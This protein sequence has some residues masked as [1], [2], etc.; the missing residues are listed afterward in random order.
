MPRS[1]S[2][3]FNRI[4][5]VVTSAAIFTFALSLF[6]FT[7][8]LWS[9]DE[10]PAEAKKVEPTSVEAVADQLEYNRG[11]KKVIGKGNVVV[12]YGNVKLTAD[13]AEVETE[14]KRAYA[15]GHVIIIK[16]DHVAARGEEVYYDFGNDK[17][18]FPNG[19]AVEEPWFA[20]GKKV[21]QVGKDKIE[22]ENGGVTTCDLERPHYEVRAKK[23][24]IYTGDKM[25]AKDVTIEILGKKVFWWPY[26]VIPLNDNGESPFEIQPGYSSRAGAYILTSKGISINKSMWGRV[27]LDWRSKRGVG[28]GVDLGYHFEK[29]NTRGSLQTY[30]TQDHVAPHAGAENPYSV[31]EERIRGR[32]TWKQRTNFDPD[33]YAMLRF[34]K[35]SD[36]HVL[37]DFFHKEFRADVDPTSFAVF[38]KNT[39]RFGFYAFNQKKM[40]RYENVIEKLPEVRFDWKTAPILSDKVYYENEWSLSNLNQKYKRA[41][42]DDNTFRFDTFHQLSSPQKWHEIKLTPA[43]NLRETMYSRSQYDN[44]PLARTAFGGFVD[45]RTQFYK[46][47]DA[48]ADF[49][50]IEINQLRHVLEPV[51][52]YDTVLQSNVSRYKLHQF[53]SIDAI[54]DAN[55]VSFGVENR[56]QTKRVVE[57]KMKRVDLV[58]LNTYLSYDFHPDEE[59]SRSGFSILNGELQIRPYEWLQYQIRYEYDMTRDNFREF[60]QDFVAHTGRFRFVFGHRS[61]AKS[62]YLNLDGNDQFVFDANVWI[63]TRWSVGGY[64]RWNQS[65]VNIEEWQ[66]SATRDLHDFLLDF[67]YNVR[68]SLI[69]DSNKE[70]F[71]LLRLKAFPQYPLRTGN[72]ASFGQP[73]IGTTVAGSNQASAGAA[74]E[75]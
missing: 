57:G 35:A 44:D 39:D 24:K 38:T 4:P 69:D 71:F 31:E 20:R 11:D 32:L 2:L 13:Y 10:K 28:G 22:I 55:K 42:P 75:G 64:I 51:V 47:Y 73:R 36:E 49:A 29:L 23:V 12:T 21:D 56:I 53:D 67:G 45:L 40:N 59:Y 5:Q 18:Q 63:N 3:R 54:D 70:L 43:V 7:S 27:H 72:R 8:L 48:T 37:Q 26:L 41:I 17:G 1:S 65:S 61:V 30:L 9:A 58:S 19:K 66:I 6:S 33:T 68:N 52:R 34:H 74:Y 15:K 16:G 14:A 62:L 50:G 25:V 60:N 46:T